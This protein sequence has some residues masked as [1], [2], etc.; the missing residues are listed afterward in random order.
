VETNKILNAIKWIGSFA[1][2]VWVLIF[3]SGMQFIEPTAGDY[4]LIGLLVIWLISAVL[5]ATYVVPTFNWLWKLLYRYEAR[6]SP[7]LYASFQE[8]SMKIKPYA[9][10]YPIITS[11]VFA[12]FVIYL[13]AGMITITGAWTLWG[14]LYW[15]IHPIIILI[16]LVVHVVQNIEVV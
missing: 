16:G 8:S 13:L 10:F 7:R 2:I 14:T 1:A 5:Y 11:V 12:M 3:L 6:I 9:N 15:I 4:T